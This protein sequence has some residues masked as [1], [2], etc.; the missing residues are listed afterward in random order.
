A[1]ELSPDFGFAWA[2][3]A[4]LE[5]SFGR[6]LRAFKDAEHSLELAPRNA[7]AHALQGFLLS[8]ENRIGAARRSFNEAI[9]LDGALGNAW[10]GRGLTY[11]RQGKGES[12]RRDWQ[13]AEVL[14]P[15]RPILP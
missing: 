12:G 10:L 5:F 6:T 15:N 1:A 3:V 13:T 11:I 8:A 7:Q 4:E 2:R 9:E 14:E